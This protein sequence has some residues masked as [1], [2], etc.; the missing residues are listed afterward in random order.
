[1]RGKRKLK[2]TK[3]S[4]RKISAHVFSSW[5]KTNVN[6]IKKSVLVAWILQDSYRLFCFN[7]DPEAQKLKGWFKAA[8]NRSPEISVS[9]SLTYLSESVC[10]YFYI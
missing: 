8:F 7:K 6:K 1:M 5:Y 10:L 3:G 2:K 9:V 4:E